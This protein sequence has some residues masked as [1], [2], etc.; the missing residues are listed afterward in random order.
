[1]KSIVRR[2]QELTVRKASCLAFAVMGG[3]LAAGCASDSR[4]VVVG[5]PATL[6]TTSDYCAVAQKEIAA[7]RVPARN[8]MVTDYQAFARAKPSVNPLETLEFVGYA[9]P[10]RKQ[11]RM[12]SCKLH[13]AA[14]IRAEYGATAA[15]E[16]TSCA[17][18]N[19]RTLDAV[20][21]TMTERQ[22]KKMPFKGPVPVMLEPDQQA[23]SET[24]WLEAFTM[25]E[26]DAGGTLRIR[27]K[28]LGGNPGNVHVSTRPNP[29]AAVQY[30]HLIAPDYLKRILLGEVKL[31]QSEFPAAGQTAAR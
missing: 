13:S 7:S 23:T 29:N 12:I 2:R 16:A 26:T 24:D 9:D 14:R 20:M 27:A 22:K 15:G 30:C 25:V 5:Q 3:L 10:Q 31:P 11:A 17:R 21:L 1:M 8:V 28:S 18:L 4:P 19:R 6:A